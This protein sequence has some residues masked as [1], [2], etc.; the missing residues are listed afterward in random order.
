MESPENIDIN[1]DL[2]LLMKVNKYIT[3]S[4]NTTL[5]YDHDITISQDKDG[6]GLNEINGPRTQFKETFSVG[7]SYKL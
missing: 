7:F 1:G 6:D 4:I 5:I 3:V 2:L